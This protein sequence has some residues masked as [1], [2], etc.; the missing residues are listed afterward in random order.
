MALTNDTSTDFSTSTGY[1]LFGSA[2]ITGGQGTLTGTGVTSGAIRTPQIDSVAWG[3]VC[4]L[5][6]TQTEMRGFRVRY[7]LSFSNWAGTGR[8]YYVLRTPAGYQN[9]ASDLTS[10]ADLI[11]L[12]NT[13][14]MAGTDVANLREFPREAQGQVSV[15]VGLSRT[16]DSATGGVQQLT[17]SHGTETLTVPGEGTTSTDD[18]PFEPE[19]GYSLQFVDYIEVTNF[20]SGYQQVVKRATAIRLQTSLTWTLNIADAATLETFLRGKVTA[21]FRWKPNGHAAPYQWR[22]RSGSIQTSPLGANGRRV[23]ASIREVL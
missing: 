20:Y 17:W 23:L 16:I 12:T 18:L 15:L 1:T 6:P 8:R 19:F 10:S 9:V 21:N 4:K 14:G 3:P 13:F 2:T 22:V 11:L 5:V 7:L